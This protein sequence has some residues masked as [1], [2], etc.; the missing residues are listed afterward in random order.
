MLP[1]IEAAVSYL[2]KVPTGSVLIT[3]MEQIKPAIK[4]KAG[5]RIRLAMGFSLTGLLAEGIVIE[6][7]LCCKKTF[8]NYFEVLEN[9]LKRICQAC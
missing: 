8:E 7:P 9:T 6:N 1:K 4:G 2:E 3:S 5:T